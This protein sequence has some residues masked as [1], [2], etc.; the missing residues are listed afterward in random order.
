L[1]W[2]EL[3]ETKKS[4]LALATVVIFLTVAFVC[5][6]AYH[7]S[8]NLQQ[9]QHFPP[10]GWAPILEI[11]DSWKLALTSKKANY[12][13]TITVIGKETV[14]NVSCNVM[15]LFFEPEN[16]L[17]HKGVSNEMTWWLDNSTLHLMRGEGKAHAYGY[18]LTFVEEHFY[19][20]EGEMFLTVGN[21]HNE[22][23][24][25]EMNVYGPPP[26][27]LLFMHEETTTPTRIKVEAIENITVPA[28]TFSCYKIATYD[29]NGQ[30]ILSTKWFSMKAKTAVK[31]ENY[32]TGE[33]EIFETAELLSYSLQ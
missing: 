24:S 21:E 9:R 31:T 17:V 13:L 22:T 14:N 6:V 25:R 7:N 8:P 33:F 32:E 11:G 20:F 12:N 30:S 4:K 19:R 1:K 27:N 18:D 26:T 5:I 29:E 10:V 2:F 3:L 28:G 16:P 15:K 23:D